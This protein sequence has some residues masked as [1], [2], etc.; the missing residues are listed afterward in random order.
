MSTPRFLAFMPFIFEWEGG[1]DNDPDDPGGETKYGIDKR[2]HPNEDIKNLTKERAQEIYFAEYWQKARCEE[3]PKNVGEVVMNIAVNA[4]HGRAGKWL[5]QACNEFYS[6][7]DLVVDGSIGPKTIAAAVEVEQLF[8]HKVLAEALLDRTEQHYRSIAR[9][10]LAKF[11]KG[12]LN[13]NNS[14]RRWVAAH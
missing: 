7:S 2:S 10:R 1:Y 6:G 5:Q 13:R 3:L 9:G 8:P 11:L 4:G 12:W 14:L